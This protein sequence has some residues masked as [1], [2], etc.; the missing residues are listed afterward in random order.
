MAISTYAN[1]QSAIGDF[2]NRSDLATNQSDGTTVIEKF[3]A[4]AEAEFNEGSDSDLWSID[5]PFQCR[6]NIRISQVLK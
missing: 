3:I 6:V 2:L 5:Q 4:L 1:L